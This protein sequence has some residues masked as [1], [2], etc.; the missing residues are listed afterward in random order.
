MAALDVLDEQRRRSLDA[1]AAG[2]VIGLQGGAI[3]P[4][5]G[6]AEGGEAHVRHLRDLLGHVLGMHGHRGQ[7]LVGAP[8]QALQHGDRFSVIRRL[9]ED[10]AV[11]GD[12]GVG[13]Q[14]R[15]QRLA[16]LQQDVEGE[17]A[18]G[19]GHARHVI[20]D[21]FARQHV[22]ADV[23]RAARVAAQQHQFE[24]DPDLAQQF[25]PARA[26]GCEVDFVVLVFHRCSCSGWGPL[27]PGG[28]DGS[29]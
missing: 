7:H 17:S 6:R 29:G 15:A 25:A 11:D 23:D 1:V 4:D 26:L 13:G 28:T 22:L 18:L 14:D 9:A 24:V 8:R 5:L 10:V 12:G 20:V 3:R 21:V 2:L 27:R 16:P 19:P